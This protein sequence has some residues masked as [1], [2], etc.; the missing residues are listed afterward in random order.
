MGSCKTQDW[1]QSISIPNSPYSIALQAN[2]LT[3][4]DD[5]PIMSAKYHLPVTFCQN[6][7]TQQ[8]HGLY[9]TAKLVVVTASVCFTMRLG[10]FQFETLDSSD[11]SDR[12]WYRKLRGLCSVLLHCQCVVVVPLPI[13]VR[14]LKPWS[15]APGEVHSLTHISSDS[16]FM[17]MMM[18]NCWSVC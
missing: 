8:S 1:L 10:T 16:W 11:N 9:A 4:V 5:R 15:V 18:I 3:V 6:C 14:E 12:H 13:S 7:T 2:H 17:M